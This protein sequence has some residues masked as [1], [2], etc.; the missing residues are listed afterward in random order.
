MVKVRQPLVMLL[1]ELIF[2]QETKERFD[3]SE[4]WEKEK[5]NLTEGHK[6]EMAR[7]QQDM[8]DEKD[9][10]QKERDQMVCSSC[11]INSVIY[12]LVKAKALDFVLA[13]D[14][15][16]GEKLIDRFDVFIKLRQQYDKFWL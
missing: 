15:S 1:T 2:Q 10:L 4:K 14:R 8:E 3:L 11:L 12:V 16:K 6:K 9:K 5:K 13:T 7:L